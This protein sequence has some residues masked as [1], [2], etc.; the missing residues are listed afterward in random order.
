MGEILGTETAYTNLKGYNYYS[1]IKCNNSTT[2]LSISVSKGLYLVNVACMCATG[3]VS[4]GMSVKLTDASDT[5]ITAV[6]QSGSG[7][8][9]AYD[10]LT[11]SFSIP[12]LITSNTTLYVK[13]SCYNSTDG[14][15]LEAR[16][17]FTRANLI[18]FM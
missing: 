8:I 16:L 3:A 1:E 18:R 12:L 13:G 10:Y 5:L 6:T 14:G 15:T 4:R 17:T 9:T 11:G 7:P 2:L